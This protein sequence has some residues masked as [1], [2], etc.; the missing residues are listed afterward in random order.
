MTD[1]QLICAARTSTDYGE[2]YEM[3]DAA[4]TLEAK[5]KIDRMAAALYHAEE[6]REGMI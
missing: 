6:A 2:L 3:M 4:R 1:E 5:R